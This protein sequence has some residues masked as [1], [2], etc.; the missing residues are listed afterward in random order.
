MTRSQYLFILTVVVLIAAACVILS[1]KHEQKQ[2]EQVG[3]SLVWRHEGDSVKI[4]V[5]KLK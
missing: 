5:S 1:V 4:D 2:V 3:D